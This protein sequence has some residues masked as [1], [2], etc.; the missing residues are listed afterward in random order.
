MATRIDCHN[1]DLKLGNSLIRIR[2]KANVCLMELED[3]TFEFCV[4]YSY[5]GAFGNRGRL[6]APVSGDHCEERNLGN[7]LSIGYRVSNWIVTDR[8]VSCDLTI[9]ASY[10]R[11]NLDA[12]PILQSQHFSGPRSILSQNTS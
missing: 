4:D 1:R 12:K 6:C 10:E 3:G 5:T 7:G 9:W 2:L 11:L 8:D